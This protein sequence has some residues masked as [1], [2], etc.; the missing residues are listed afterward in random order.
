MKKRPGGRADRWVRRHG[1]GPEN[2]KAANLMDREEA[3][4]FPLNTY[5]Q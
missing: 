5:L 2:L 1:G 3:G 4:P